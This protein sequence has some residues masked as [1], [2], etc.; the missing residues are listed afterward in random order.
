M[1]V[2]GDTLFVPVADTPV[3]NDIE[4]DMAPQPGLYALDIRNGT[5][6]WKTPNT[7]DVCKGRLYCTPGL[8][9]AIT[10]SAGLVFAGSIDGWLRVYDGKTGEVVWRFDTARAFKTVGG[11]EASGGSMAGGPA[12]ILYHG[13]VILPSGYDFAHKMPGN[14][15]L[16]LQA[17]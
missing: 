5:F 2:D 10:T 16:T 4:F 17:K 7:E 1:A 3:K 13:A 14:V 15:L 6:L 12:P 11:G 8:G 9:A